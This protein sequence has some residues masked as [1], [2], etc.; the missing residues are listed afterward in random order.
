M[1]VPPTRAA[2]RLLISQL[3]ELASAIE[4]AADELLTELNAEGIEHPIL[5]TIRTVIATRAAHIMR[6]TGKAE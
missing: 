3:G 1:R 5:Q 4:P 6:I 2:Q